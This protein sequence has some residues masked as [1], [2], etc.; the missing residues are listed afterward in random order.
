MS[1]LLG[2][3]VIGGLITN[4]ANNVET[5]GLQRAM[6]RYFERSQSKIIVQGQTASLKKILQH[7]RVILVANH[8]QEIDTIA[9]LSTLPT[10]KDSYMIVT[11]VAF[12]IHK[13]LD[14]HLIPV[15]IEH[16]HKKSQ[17]NGIMRVI[18]K[19]RSLPYLTPD[20][21]H[22]K[23]IQ[24]IQEA[25]TKVSK[26]GQVII[27]P[28]SKGKNTK[29]FTGI[30]HLIKG[31]KSKEPIYVVNAYIQGASKFDFL[32]LFPGIG[33][34]LPTISITF[35]PARKVNTLQKHYPKEIT[36]QLANEYYYFVKTLTV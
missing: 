23:N 9:L 1:F 7:E 18:K 24:S 11:S 14:K 2:L 35:A 19:V 4:L 21:E 17:K 6:A 16:H 15:Y 36:K 25:S 10:R 26:G 27:F 30:G 29:W 5:I 8:P 28:T 33:K 20:E 3:P 34:I 32:R 22:E 13:S 12:G 31:I